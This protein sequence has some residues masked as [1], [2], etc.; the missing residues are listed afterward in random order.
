MPH[1]SSYPQLSHSI[2]AIH[3]E[4]WPQRQLSARDP[5]YCIGSCLAQRAAKALRQH[6]LPA[7]HAGNAPLYSPLSIANWLELVCSTSTERQKLLSSYALQGPSRL[8]YHP[9]SPGGFAAETPEQLSQQVERQCQREQSMLGAAGVLLI[10]LGSSF[11]LWHREQQV[12]WSNGHRL[13]HLEKRLLN[14]EE[15]KHSLAKI[16]RLARQ[17]A[18]QAKIILSVSPVR[19]SHLGY[20]KNSHSKAQLLCLAHSHPEGDFYYFPAFEIAIDELRDYRWYDALH[21]QLSLPAFSLIFERLLATALSAEAQN[22]VQQASKCIGLAR[23][24][25]QRPFASHDYQRCLALLTELSSP[26]PP[27][28]WPQLPKKP[29]ELIKLLQEEALEP[30]YF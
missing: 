19:H 11:A 16:L 23:H 21:N 9:Y 24:Y 25:R 17:V 4:T 13:N 10:T 5:W 28:P 7:Y 22:Y 15:L 2:P 18:P 26:P 6:L 8:Y 27:S 3:G 14:P 30:H 12:F 29:E 20:L 1:L